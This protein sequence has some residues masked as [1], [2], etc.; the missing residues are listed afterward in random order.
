MI[1]RG[2]RINCPGGEAE[3]P[4]WQFHVVRECPCGCG[5]FDCLDPNLNVWVITAYEAPFFQVLEPDQTSAKI[6]AGKMDDRF[7]E[8]IE[9]Q[10]GL[11]E[12]AFM[13]IRR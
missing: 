12:K 10:K 13:G 7:D 2:D 4:H 3:P 1:K 9:I 6:L 11:H 8:A 5:S